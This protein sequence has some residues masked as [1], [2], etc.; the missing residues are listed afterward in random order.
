MKMKKKIEKVNKLVDE[1]VNGENEW[2]THRL[3]SVTNMYTSGI[4]A[5]IQTAHSLHEMYSK[6]TDYDRLDGLTQISQEF[7]EDWANDDKTI[8]V[9]NGGYQS[10][11]QKIAILFEKVEEEYGFP[12]SEF[13]ESQDALNE[14]L[15]AIAIILP[16]QIWKLIRSKYKHVKKSK[17]KKKAPLLFKLYEAMHGLPLAT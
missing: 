1:I 17:L 14:A 13:S 5:G 11:L 6:Y 12:C 16:Q 8:I 10:N 9:L 2:N 7:I 4:H 3:Y 15:T